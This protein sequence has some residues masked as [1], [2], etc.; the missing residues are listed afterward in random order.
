MLLFYIIDEAVVA[1]GACFYGNLLR[2]DTLTAIS[3][4]GTGFTKLQ[5]KALK[6]ILFITHCT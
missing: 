4:T 3:G 6:G 5:I 1:T 2:G